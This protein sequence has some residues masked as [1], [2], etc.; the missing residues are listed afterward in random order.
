MTHE[1][2]VAAALEYLIRR[3]EAEKAARKYINPHLQLFMR[4]ERRLAQVPAGYQPCGVPV[5]EEVDH[6]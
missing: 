4:L 1:E 5:R 2:N 3:A 6:V